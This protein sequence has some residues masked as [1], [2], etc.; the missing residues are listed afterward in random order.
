MEQLSTQKRGIM[1]LIL[2]VISVS[3]FNSIETMAQ[4]VDQCQ[5]PLPQEKQVIPYRPGYND[6]FMV[7]DQMP[8]FPGGDK[9]LRQY[10][11][12]NI[13]Y[14]TNAIEKNIQGK[15][16]VGFIVEKD[17]SIDS[18]KV[19]L[20]VYPSLDTEAIRIVKAMPKWES[21]KLHGKPVRVQYAIPVTFCLPDS[22]K[23]E[24]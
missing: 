12:Q 10:L 13:Q 14:P 20:S 6:V 23:K 4:E 9:A 8:E 1:L 21:G 22:I 7:V 3:L 17:G 15:V 5:F 18:V 16:S 11:D 19:L 2:I 24:Q